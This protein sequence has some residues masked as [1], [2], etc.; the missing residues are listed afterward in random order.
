M[1]CFSMKSA[2]PSRIASTAA[3]TSV[4]SPSTITGGEVC[5]GAQPAQQLEA[6]HARQPH[7]GDHAA[8]RRIDACGSE[9]ALGAV[10]VL[11]FGVEG[12]EQ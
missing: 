3:R 9:I 7:V 2:A 10:V 12:A 1:C 6:G 5:R 11:Y 8:E 4:S